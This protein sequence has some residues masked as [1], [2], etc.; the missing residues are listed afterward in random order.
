MSDYAGRSA[1]DWYITA[2]C[3]AQLAE[4]RA[5]I[6]TLTRRAEAAEAECER[7]RADR[8][9]WQR[10]H[11]AQVQCVGW[12]RDAIAEWRKA[13]DEARAQGSRMHR[14]A[15]EA[16]RLLGL[17]MRVGYATCWPLRSES[18]HYRR[19][20]EEQQ[21]SAALWR[22]RCNKAEAKVETLTAELSAAQDAYEG[23]GYEAFQCATE[24]D[25][26]RFL[27]AGW[28]RL[29]T[30]AAK[31][32]LPE[33]D[34]HMRPVM[35]E[36]ASLRAKLARAEGVVGAARTMMAKIDARGCASDTDI[37]AALATYEEG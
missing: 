14:R 7:L 36:I 33:L 13:R 6:A 9:E 37:R 31:S 23:A 2:Q 29:A 28:R 20:A 15:Q 12:H 34:A 11:A 8:D 10:G 18:K 24:R 26:A 25:A 17:A 5:T 32:F 19:V 4:E 1:E 16:E 35:Q 27:S 22:E 21:A 30:A 3:E